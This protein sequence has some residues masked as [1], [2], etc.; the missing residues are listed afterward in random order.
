MM[1]VV[2]LG[3]GSNLGDRERFLNSAVGRLRDV[4]GLEIVAVS[5]IYESPAQETSDDSPPF[6]NQVVKLEYAFSP[7]DLQQ[8]VET[9]EDHLGRNGKG[10]RRARTIDIDIL[11]FGDKRVK[12]ERLEIPHPR[13]TRRPFVLIPLLDIDPELVHPVTGKPLAK[14]LTPAGRTQVEIYRDHVARQS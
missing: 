7:E 6:L 5:A 1:E 13:I 3:L 11:L 8:A 14:Y 9:I 4:D 10:E 2:Y 12:T